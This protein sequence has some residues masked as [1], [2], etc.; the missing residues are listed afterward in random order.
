MLLLGILVTLKVYNEEAVDDVTEVAVAL[1]LISHSLI[2]RRILLLCL[3]LLLK[4]IK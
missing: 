3:M 1:W 4:T 2:L